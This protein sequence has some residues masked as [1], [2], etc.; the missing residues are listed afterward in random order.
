MR[1][2]ECND[3]YVQTFFDVLEERFPSFINLKIKLLFDTKQR[4]SA[5]RLV[6]GSICTTS[7][8][9]KFFSKDN[10]AEDGY[11]FVLIMDQKAWDLASPVDRKRMISH[12]MRHIFIDEKGKAKLIGHELEDFYAELEL[13]KDD[14][15]W[16]RNLA[17][18]VRAMYDQEKS[19]AKKK[20]VH[21]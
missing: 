7:A 19:M 16:G 15:E 20:L 4:I 21:N 13:N 5:G 10:N 18:Q 17:V 2:I 8:M 9:T 12:E 1:Y 14:P 6:L 11:D 3:E